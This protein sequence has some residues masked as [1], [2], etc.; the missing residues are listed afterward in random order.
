MVIIV[1][2]VME[3]QIV[4]YQM[5]VRLI[6]SNDASN[7]TI[8]EVKEIKALQKYYEPLYIRWASLCL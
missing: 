6:K 7:S 1:D 4:C 5:Y 2:M 8:D 3:A